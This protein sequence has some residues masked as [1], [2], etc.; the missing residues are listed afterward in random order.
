MY[1]QETCMDI[2]A[3]QIDVLGHYDKNYQ[4]SMKQQFHQ[5]SLIALKGDTSM[6]HQ[7]IINLNNAI[8]FYRSWFP[9]N[10]LNQEVHEKL[11]ELEKRVSKH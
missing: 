6:M 5:S 2:I 11:S 3:T 7:L 8:D 4:Y 10:E 9:E 1:N